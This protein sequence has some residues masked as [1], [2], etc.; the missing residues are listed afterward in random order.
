MRRVVITGPSG[1]GKSRLAREIGAR[2]ALPVLHLDS[3][4][5][6]P[7]WVMRPKAEVGEELLGWYARE[8]WVIEGNYTSAP[9]FETR[10]ARADTYVWLDLPLAL[11]YWRVTRRTFASLGRPRPDL[12]PGCP[13][14]FGPA[15]IELFSYMWRTRKTHRNTLAAVF[16][17]LP[18]HITGHHLTSR[19]AVAAFVETLS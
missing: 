14:G 2:C 15:K 5:W 17:G 13:E 8:A 3:A 12:A 1:S 11:R 10:L 4:F 18:A 6:S 16:A 7:G 9:G 19:R